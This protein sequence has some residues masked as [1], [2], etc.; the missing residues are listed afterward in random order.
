MINHHHQKLNKKD[1]KQIIILGDSMIKH[2][3]EEEI[4]RKLQGNCKAYVKHF[5]G[6]RAKYMKDYI[7]PS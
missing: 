1:H 2:V 3:N 6:V 4:S 5:S 7:K